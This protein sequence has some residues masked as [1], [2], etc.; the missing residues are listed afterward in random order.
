MIG[1]NAARE[2]ELDP[3]ATDRLLGVCTADSSASNESRRRLRDG[4]AA[5][6]TAAICLA[7]LVADLVRRRGMVGRF[8]YLGLEV[9]KLSSEVRFLSSGAEPGASESLRFLTFES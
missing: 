1:R 5:D 4:P 2:G 9:F 7:S 3:A 6:A 8:L